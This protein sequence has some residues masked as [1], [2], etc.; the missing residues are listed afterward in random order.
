VG[1]YSFDVRLSHPFLPA[2]LSRRTTKPGQVHWMNYYGRFY[3]SQCVRVLHHLNWAL[4]AWVRWKFK[5]FRRR[6]SASMRWLA[7]VA[8]RD[9]K[10]LVLWQLGV[11]PYE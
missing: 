6:K 3:R 11:V 10:L 5:R 1:R 9:R 8:K 2:G 7:R 4:A